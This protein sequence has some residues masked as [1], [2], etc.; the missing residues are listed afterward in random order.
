VRRAL[1]LVVLSGVVGAGLAAQAPDRKRLPAS[2]PARAL[3]LP[4]IQKRR[5]SNG[6]PVW[7]VE[8]HEVPVAQVN[9]LLMSGTGDD[10]TGRFGIASLTA[11]ML[12]EGAGSRPSLELADAIDFLGASLSAFSSVDSS[13]VRLHV[14][15]ARLREALPLMAD[16]VQRPTFPA[17]ELERLRQQRLTSLLQSRDDPDAIASL[18]FSRV[19]Y[20]RSHRYGTALMGAADTIKAFTVGDL[21]AFYESAYRPDNGTLIVVGDVV[22]DSVLPL[23]ETHFGGW[24]AKGGAVA[25]AS[26]PSAGEPKSRQVILIDKPDAPQSQIRIGSV[27]AARS[28]ADFFPIQV[29]NTVL[30][31]A[32]S[33]RL[34][35]NLR[36]KHGYTYGARSSFDLRKFPGPFTAAAGVQTD[37]T[38][39]SLTEFFNELN[40]MLKEVPDD[41][42]ARARNYVALRFPT[43]FET[44][45]DISGRLESLIV[46]GLPDDY[47]AT[48]VQMIQ[49]V[50]AAEVQ[51]VARKYIQPD[52]LTVV[53]VGDRKMVEARIRAL[54]L[55][56]VREMTIDEVFAAPQ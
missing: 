38:A 55:G 7:I 17:E 46:Y 30:G 18:A 10:P 9:L 45:A 26:L 48:Y 6:L 52:R 36:E 25:K 24:K 5:L 34:N 11:A 50:T 54:N 27:S 12:T 1:A 53:V 28:T 44:T 37:K 32:F 39:E 4:A 16:V 33:S 51:R 41:E 56:P 29:M 19:V 15:V 13:A 42:L 43:T 20:G 49:A 22:P 8:Q 23:L 14:P 21:R 40:G 2:G 47:Y 3:E 31:G 35:L